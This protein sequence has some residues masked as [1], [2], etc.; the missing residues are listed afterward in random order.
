MYL[1]FFDE[2]G[3]LDDA[4]ENHSLYGGLG[5]TREDYTDISSHFDS[6]GWT[7]ELH[8]RDFTLKHLNKYLN[9]LDYV[10]DKNIIMNSIIVSRDDAKETAD[11]LKLTMSRMR[12]LFYIKIPERMIYGILRD[13]ETYKTIKIVYDKCSEYEKYDLKGKLEHQLNAHLV[14]KNLHCQIT[15]VKDE[16]SKDEQMLQIT[17]VLLGIINYLVDKKYYSLKDIRLTEADY[18][19][20]INHDKFSGAE[21]TFIESCYSL[22]DNKYELVEKNDGK[23]RV[24]SDLF[25]RENIYTKSSVMKTEFIYRLID[26]PE[27]LKRLNSIKLF[28]WNG[29]ESINF[30]NVNDYI[31]E[32]YH[33]KSKFDNYNK[34]RM[35]KHYKDHPEATLK[36]YQKLLGYGSNM[37]KLV[38]RYRSEIDL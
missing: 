2:S 29:E 23:L 32:F 5:C 36:D 14:Y 1:V 6:L 34:I 9:A 22:G 31:A 38:Q 33:F 13:L 26:N 18:N 28:Y 19:Y 21:K 16:D 7:T 35:I 11:R 30:M 25:T 20:I 37:K 12:E 15:N 24:L 4:S 10:L 3:K 27:K 8:F 17:D